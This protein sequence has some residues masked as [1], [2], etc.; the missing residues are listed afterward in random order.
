VSTYQKK[1][2]IQPV[3]K[4]KCNWIFSISKFFQ[5]PVDFILPEGRANKSAYSKQEFSSPQK[6]ESLMVKYESQDFHLI[7]IAKTFN[8]E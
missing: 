1:V 4:S 7:L 3:G 8:I 2:L 5:S 6:N